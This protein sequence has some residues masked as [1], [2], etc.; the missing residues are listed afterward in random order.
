[1]PWMFVIILRGM[2][3]HNSWPS[4]PCHRQL[5]CF[6]WNDSLL[7]IVKSHTFL[8]WLS[9]DDYENIRGFWKN[10]QWEVF[11]LSLRSQ[12]GMWTAWELRK[13]NNIPDN[14]ST[15]KNQIVKSN[16]CTLFLWHSIF[17]LY[18]CDSQTLWRKRYIHRAVITS[19]LW[20]L[21]VCIRSCFVKLA[22]EVLLGFIYLSNNCAW[23]HY[24]HDGKA[25]VVIMTLATTI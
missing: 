24:K 2:N 9:T 7:R 16:L 19:G 20:L 8:L 15:L 6:H 21:R 11:C 10:G 25:C 14:L 18:N 1:M 17:E 12:S 13:G 5:L 3:K 4:V 22:K 23:W